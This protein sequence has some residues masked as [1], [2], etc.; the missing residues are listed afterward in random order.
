LTGFGGLIAHDRLQ[1]VT[2]NLRPRNGSVAIAET[3]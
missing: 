3:P 2:Y 1:A